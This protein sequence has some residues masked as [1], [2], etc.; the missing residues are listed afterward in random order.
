MTT[1]WNYFNLGIACINL[2]ELGSDVKVNLELAEWNF[3]KAIEIRPEGYKAHYN[4]GYVYMKEEKYDEAMR[5]FD[6][7]LQLNSAHLPSLYYGALTRHVK[8]FLL[9][10]ERDINKMSKAERLLDEAIE[11]YQIVKTIN[12]TL[13]PAIENNLANAQSLLEDIKKIR[14]TER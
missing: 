1:Y 3:R 7:A 8:A 4:L 13:F 12:P 6:D 10:K 11:Q 5:C 14:R 9:F 2:A